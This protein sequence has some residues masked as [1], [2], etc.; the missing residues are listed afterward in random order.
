MKPARC[1]MRNAM[2]ASVLLILVVGA[3]LLAAGCWDVAEVDHRGFISTLGVDLDKGGK[4]I[5]TAVIPIP[6]AIAGGGMGG[7]GGP[8]GPSMQIISASGDT[9]A[10]A[11]GRLGEKTDR[12]TDLGHLRHV[13]IGEHL[14]KSG[15]DHRVDVLFRHP[16]MDGT[17][18]VMVCEGEARKIIGVNPPSETFPVVYLERYFYKDGLDTPIFLR[19]ELWKTYVLLNTSS[20]QLFLPKLKATRAKPPKEGAG[21]QGGQGG[22]RAQGGTTEEDQDKIEIT[23]FGLFRDKRLVGWIE[24]KEAAAFSWLMG[25]RKGANVVVEVPSAGKRKAT[26]QVL[27]IRTMRVVRKEGDRF[28]ITIMVRGAM[29][30]LEGQDI[31]LLPGD[32]RIH[33]EIVEECQKVIRSQVEKLIHKL[34]VEL[35]TD[36][37]SL[38]ENVRRQFPGEWDPD[39]WKEE[40]PRVR[41]ETRVTVT[42]SQLGVIH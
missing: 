27:D 35:R 25:D 12:L 33:R 2:R 3:S 29:N 9:L 15:L 18:A 6:R 28:A 19:V 34:Q 8:S 17:A 38:G 13:I 4:F 14:A 32:D 11:L 39:S 42:V 41:I 37:L 21:G 10:D 7:G 40:F 26:L 1:L 5:V 16:A 20:R 36:A 23:G 22:G 30:L 24:G 31:H